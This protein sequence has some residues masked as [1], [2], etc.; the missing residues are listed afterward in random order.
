[1]SAT[2]SAASAER[3]AANDTND[4]ILEL[5]DLRV[6]FRTLSGP[7]QAVDIDHL[8]VRRAEILGLVGETGSGKSVTALSVLR[9]L[10]PQKTRTEGKV[11]F[12]GRNL[13][14]ET[15][16][17]MRAIRGREITMVF[18]DPASSLNPVFPVGEPLTRIIAIHQ[19]LSLREAREKAVEVLARVRLPNPREIL[20][21]Y[22]HELSGGMR[23][24]VM[25]GM[26]LSSNPDLLFAD[27]PTTA[28]DVTIQAQILR[29]VRELRAEFSASIVFITHNLGVVAQLADRVAVMYAGR[30]VEV[31]PARDVFR[32]PAHPY[33][34][35]L[36]KAVPRLGQKRDR[37]PVIEGT[38][39]VIR[40]PAPTCYFA[41]RCPRRSE[42]CTAVRPRL[43]EVGPGHV[44]ACL[45]PADL[46]AD[47]AVDLAADR[48]VELAADR[49]VDPAADRT[50][51]RAKGG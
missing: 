20:G 3:S 49:T 13:L 2:S 17:R 10:P 18:Q 32:R 48:A 14:T 50:V 36:L 46:A 44:A 12:K 28:L 15:E 5:E 22:P 16:A 27:E 7:V 4:T 43:T 41:P 37:L 21:R 25:I 33:T 35:L 47:R 26:A 42:A 31:G 40:S 39:P 6:G 23:Q 11:L 29:L 51:G 8:A 24:R 30:V 38:V 19:G 45:R 9:L 34:E 1:M